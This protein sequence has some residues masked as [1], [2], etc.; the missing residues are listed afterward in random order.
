MLRWHTALPVLALGGVASFPFFACSGGDSEVAVPS[1]A[2]GSGFEGGSDAGSAGSSDASSE[3]GSVIV[4]TDGGCPSHIFC[5][6]Q[7]V[8]CPEGNECYEGQCVLSC[9]SGVH[10]GEG[11]SATCCAAGQVCLSSTCE[12]PGEACDDSY[13]CPENHFCE[14]TIG[15]C[16]PQPSGASL[17]EFKPPVLPFN[18]VVEWSW[19]SSTIHPTFLQVVNTPIVA[20]LDSDLIPDVVIVTSEDYTA[21]PTGVA[22]L[23][24][25]DGATGLEK[26]GA[27]VDAYKAQY[28]VN[29]RSCPALADIDG[30]GDIEIVAS[31][32]S[33]GFIAFEADGSVKWTS[34]LA[35]G[36]TAY[37]ETSASSAVAIAHMD[38]DGKPDIVV[39]GVVLSNEGKLVSGQGNA[40]TASNPAGYGGVSIIADV[41]D[42]GVQD[43]VTGRRA[44]KIDGTLLWDNAKTDGY[45]AIADLDGD[46][47][48][49]LVVVAAGDVR[50]H[51][52]KTGVQ[53][54]AIDMPGSGAGG[55]PTIAD[56]DADGVMEIASANGS[57]YNVFEYVSSPAP[58][59]TA[60]WSKDTQDLSSNVTGSSVFDFEG[61]GAAEVVYGDECYFRV[62][63]GKDGTVLF[64]V[65]NSSATIH[66]YPVVV[67]VDGDNNT[68][69]VVVAN[70][71]NHGPGGNVC[72]GYTG[73]EAPKH[74]VFVYGDAN[75]KWVR[76]RKI[77][78]Q[79]AYHITNINAD[80]T[81]PNPEPKSWA[82][83]QGFNNYRVSTQ[84]AGVYNAPDLA[85]D[86]E[87]SS[88]SCPAGL[89]LRARVKNLGALGVPAGVDVSF[90]LGNDP[91]TGKLLGEGKTTKA[92]LPGE[93][94]IVSITFSPDSGDTPPWKFTVVVD[95]KVAGSS[96]VDECLEDNNQA[97]AGGV[98]CPSV[99]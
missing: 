75:D 95:G 2:G 90:Y 55:P 76:T 52:A 66:E 29:P 36:V 32:G 26:W 65:A 14:P 93:S 12:T 58:A 83:P 56:F 53:L 9:A 41:D 74:G 59:L 71:K 42:D 35:D 5:G 47:K 50:V 19:T 3:D 85:V 87:I 6:A 24:A 88:A 8:C 18:P 72:A 79:H 45:P 43:V 11:A 17:C 64:Q 4:P 54:A 86:L 44:W 92:L 82:K 37:N 40:K 81:L 21:D 94:Q 30:D 70:D 57:M 63:S 20:D 39:G 98:Q 28:A 22:Y 89:E 49:E 60:K 33:G 77:W 34:T 48:P 13:D 15:K 84:G 80:G 99:K 16:L 31:K 23:R 91:S 96:A 10:C 61:D 97:Q 73:S 78:N 69:I 25:L 68:E 38:G 46:G 1:N 7:V 67:D 51:D 27:G 62:Y